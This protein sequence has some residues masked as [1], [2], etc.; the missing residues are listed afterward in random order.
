MEWYFDP[1]IF[2]LEKKRVLEAGP[3]YVGHELMVP[4]RGDYR[5]L[6]QL[7]HAKMLVRNDAGVELLSGEL[8]QHLQHR[9]AGLAAVTFHGPDQALVGERRHAIEEI[10]A[11]LVGRITD[12]LG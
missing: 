3:N 5:T 8:A 7:D 12:R 4:N 2:A 1:E 11:Q 9:E 10:D 6:P